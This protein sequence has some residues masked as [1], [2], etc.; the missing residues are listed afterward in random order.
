MNHIETKDKF[1]NI[2]K[3]IG[4]FFNDT[5]QKIALANA[6]FLS[7]HLDYSM[8]EWYHSRNVHL[9]NFLKQVNKTINA[10]REQALK[11]ILAGLDG[12]NLEKKDIESI[13][14]SINKGYDILIKE[15]SKS[16]KR[17]LP[18]IF[19][20]SKVADKVLKS[21]PAEALR[22]TITDYLN[23]NTLAYIDYLNADGEVVRR[24]QWENWM[25]MVVRTELQADATKTLI[26]TGKETGAIF[27]TCSYYGDCAPDHVEMQA[28][29]LFVDKDW[30]SNAPEDRIE[31]IEN[32]IAYHKIPTIQEVS[33]NAPY[34]TTR[35]NCRHFFQYVS[36][37]DV[38]GIKNKEDLNKYRVE[39]NLTSEGKYKP[40]KYEALQKQR[41]N[42]RKIRNLKGQMEQAQALGDKQQEAIMKRKVLNAQ[43]EQRELLK[44]NTF[45]ER[46]YDREAYR[47]MITNF[48]IR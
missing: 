2:S 31:E 36:L 41:T 27:Y 8:Q 6:E 10:D 19:S 23:K 42:E 38:L 46:N 25:E 1:D 37:D 39:N 20:S 13:K 5:K 34:F 28:K 48:R 18:R 33:E 24:V 12:F 11:S 43:K 35:P 47:K 26:A 7:Q 32:Y 45:L 16:V 4:D 14:Q 22:N 30:R 21:G 15:S 29:G 9:N 44:E 3:I 40:E 17:E